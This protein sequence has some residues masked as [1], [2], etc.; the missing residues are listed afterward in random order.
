VK[1]KRK[2][3]KETRKE[4]RRR[5]KT[6]SWEGKNRKQNA[7]FSEEKSFKKTYLAY[8]RGCH[9]SENNFQATKFSATETKILQQSELLL[10]EPFLPQRTSTQKQMTQLL[11][12]RPYP[13]FH[14]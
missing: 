9:I 4:T 10:Y 8:T 2:S 3:S 13:S 14:T 11:A 1:V 5:T 12:K 7:S 6:R